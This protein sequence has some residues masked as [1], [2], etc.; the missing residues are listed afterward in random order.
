M[1]A[2]N[3]LC[4]TLCEASSSSREYMKNTWIVSAS[5]FLFTPAA[6]VADTALPVSA[7]HAMVVT[8][9]RAASQVGIDI[10]KAGGNAIDA[11]VAVGYAL[12]VVNPCCGN[13]G[14]G[15]FMLV[16]FANGKNTVINFRGKAPL[17]ANKN[18]FLD[19]NGKLKPGSTTSGYLSASIPGTVLGLDTALS[20]YGSMSR[21]QVMAPAI[22]LAQQGYRVS[23]YD[24]EWF[25][26]Y[27][28]AFRSQRNAAA[29]FLKK[30][31][32]Y[33]SGELLIQ[34]DLANTLKL[35][36]EKGPDAFYKGSIAQQIVKSSQAHGGIMTRQDFAQYSVEE[37]TPIW[38][39]YHGY[40]VISVPPPSS[41]GVTLCEMLSLLQN[42]PLQDNNYQSAKNIHYIV[43]SMR[44]AFYDRNTQLGDP[45]FV[46][47]PVKKLLSNQYTSQLS[48]RILNTTEIKPEDL[49]VDIHEQTD[50]THYSIIDTKGNAVAVTYTIN[51]FF[52]ANVI[53]D[54]LGFFLND[55]MDDFT[56]SPGQ[57][58]KFNLIQSSKNHIES[59]KRPLSSMAPTIIMNNKNV[60]MVL[61]SPGGPRIITTV[62]LTLLNV[63]DNGMNI[64]QAIDTP[65]YHY[66]GIPDVIDV[67]PLAFSYLTALNL[68]MMGYRLRS[69][70]TWAAV[71]A[72]LI[73]QKDKT[74]YGANDYRRPDGAALGY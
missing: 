4:H 13:I 59:G 64:K 37:L 25:A 1:G 52:G 8:E 70:P 50:T 15:G 33:D 2:L 32:P 60:F 7:K 57:T 74:I 55:D 12:A 43:E 72:I 5:F 67:E 45:N 36:A 46:N 51:G 21:K 23:D 69:Q 47:N 71:E 11:A 22:K 30:G 62:L 34:T 29:I 28:P 49:M 3:N 31:K 48:Q 19:T 63:I 44:Y 42:L 56:V 41:G 20:K 73:D 53:P 68:K 61:G 26:I 58:N 24:T 54:H 10:L 18:M 27:T 35:I 14:G 6:C 38:C 16:H 17:K 39:Q 65:R 9:K 40:S 66:Q